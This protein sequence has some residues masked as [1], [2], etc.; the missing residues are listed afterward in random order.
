MIP[1]VLKRPCRGLRALGLAAAIGAA[2]TVQAQTAQIQLPALPTPPAVTVAGFYVGPF[3]GTLLSDPTLPTISFFYTN[4]F[5]FINWGQQWQGGVTN[6]GQTNLSSTMFGSAAIDTYRKAAWLTTQVDLNTP[7]PTRADVQVA[8]WSLFWPGISVAN[9][10]GQSWVNAAN[11]FF[12]SS[13]YS[14]FD[15]SQHSVLTAN[16]GSNY[17]GPQEFIVG[18]QYFL[19]PTVTPPDLTPVVTPEPATWL[20]LGTGLIAMLSVAVVR[21]I[22]V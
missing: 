6:L 14:T 13:S 11:S 1:P 3:S 2:T 9:F 22:R 19:P 16:S 12:S 18:S 20:L 17:P 4:L 15:W 10:T 8:I 7:A 5:S 21:G